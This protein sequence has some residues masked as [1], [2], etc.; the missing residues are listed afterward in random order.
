MHFLADCGRYL[1]VKTTEGH[2]FKRVLVQRAIFEEH[3]KDASEGLHPLYR[4]LHSRLEVIVKTRGLSSRVELQRTPMHINAANG[5]VFISHR[6][7]VFPSG[8]LPLSAGNVRR[9]PLADIYRS[10]PLFHELRDPDRL[11]G[12]CG[13]C[14]FKRLC[15]GSRSR[16][17]AFSGDPHDEDPYCAYRPGSFPF[18]EALARRLRTEM[19][20][21]TRSN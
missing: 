10:A 15:A 2:H 19:P 6:G 9:Q 21:T 18:P 4:R 3:G 8:F 7:D 16:A 13:A 1:S 11:K 14:E 20:E 17:F 5:F 12:R